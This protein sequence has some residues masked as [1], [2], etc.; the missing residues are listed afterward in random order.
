MKYLEAQKRFKNI[1]Y[2]LSKHSKNTNFKLDGIFKSLFQEG[3][4]EDESRFAILELLKSDQSSCMEAYRN[5]Q[6]VLDV[7]AH[8]HYLL[9]KREIEDFLQQLNSDEKSRNIDGILKARLNH[10]NVLKRDGAEDALVN[11]FAKY[12]TDNSHQVE[13][14]GDWEEAPMMLMKTYAASSILLSDLNA[15]IFEVIYEGFE[16]KVPVSSEIL[17][18][19]LQEVLKSEQIVNKDT[20]SECSSRERSNVHF[21]EVS[22][23]GNNRGIFSD[24]LNEQ[25]AEV[26]RRIS[27]LIAI[28]QLVAN[29]ISSTSRLLHSK[30]LRQSGMWELCSVGAVRVIYCRTGEGDVV[31]L[32]GIDKK[33][34]DWTQEDLIKKCRLLKERLESGDKN[35]LLIEI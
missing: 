28:N 26:A 15:L 1:S 12:I 24:W 34:R 4:F 10:E 23:N 13:F 21:Y 8:P 5:L 35:V 11:Y 16:S 3:R 18:D 22:V 29:S 19:R 25:G 27:S 31:L 7:N 17:F 33:G 30:P 20:C 32:G 2:W 6:K 14:S 9:S